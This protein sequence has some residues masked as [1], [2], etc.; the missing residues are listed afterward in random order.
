[1][2][3]LR[4]L[5]PS[6]AVET[7]L[8]LDQPRHSKRP[9]IDA[10]KATTYQEWCILHPSWQ[11]VLS[12]HTTEYAAT[13]LT[14]T[15]LPHDDVWCKFAL[16]FAV[17]NG[18]RDVVKWV[19][20]TFNP[21]IEA[22]T[23]LNAAGP[24]NENDPLG[25]IILY[26]HRVH[27]LWTV[28][29]LFRH[30]LTHNRLELVEHMLMSMNMN[31]NM[32][33]EWRKFVDS[34]RYKITNCLSPTQK[35]RMCV[36][37]ALLIRL[38]DPVPLPTPG[39]MCHPIVE[40]CYDRMTD[41]DKA[42]RSALLTTALP[43]PIISEILGYTQSPLGVVDSIPVQFLYRYKSQQILYGYKP[44]YTTLRDRELILSHV[45]IPF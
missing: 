17:G 42:T 4:R 29:E 33:C 43:L 12:C 19:I 39:K 41:T 6:Q 13:L 38:Q 8:Y 25:C 9:L 10:L 37:M 31:I 3:S 20:E 27:N 1:V 32:C 16:E 22:Y 45:P 30:M 14:S 2:K 34:A 26:L 40:S 7:C 11:R 35:T 18:C 15:E 21:T 23:L 28:E 24:K 36:F 44:T 5:P